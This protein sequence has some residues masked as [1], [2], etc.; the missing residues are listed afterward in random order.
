MDE[1]TVIVGL[2]LWRLVVA[3]LAS[4]I[5]ALALAMA[6]PAISPLL[7][8]AIVILGVVLGI[9]W[10]SKATFPSAS[11][12]PP[13]S[14]LVAF[15]GLAFIGVVWGGLLELATG[16]SVAAAA[17]LAA[18]PTLFSPAVVLI[19]KRALPVRQLTFATIAFTAGFAIIYAIHRFAPGAGA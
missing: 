2:I 1:I 11:V 13:I 12:E 9:V 16:S 14:G 10:Q 4:V 5:G 17:L 6:I 3:T 7:G 18:T 19:T 15:L 8:F